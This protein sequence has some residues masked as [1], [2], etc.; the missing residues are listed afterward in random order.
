MSTL[1][2]REDVIVV[3]SISCIYGA[4][5]PND[6]KKLSIE[7][8]VGDTINRDDLMIT[9]ISMLYERSM[10]LESGKFRV[11][12]DTIDIYPAY[13]DQIIRLELFGDDI[14]RISILHPVTGEIITQIDQIKLFPAKQFVVPESKQE[15]AIQ[16]MLAELKERLPQLEPLEAERLKKRVNY[17]I[18]MIR[19]VG[20][21]SGIENYSRLFDGR[22]VGAPPYC[23]LDYFPKDFLLIIDESHQSLPQSRA[24]YKGDF[25]RKK[26]LVDFGFRL[27]CAYDNRPLKFVEFEKYFKHTLFVSATPGPYELENSTNIVELIIRPTGLLDPLVEVRPITGQIAD[28]EKEIKKTV[29]KGQRVLLTTL[30]K[31]QAEDLTDFLAKREVKVRYMHSD[32]DT[33]DRIEL[34]RQLRS[35]E[36]DVLVGINLLREGLDLPEVS[37]VCILDADKEGFLRNDTS[38]I[39]TIGRAARNTEGRVIMYADRETKSMKKAIEITRK[40]RQAQIAYNKIHNIVP[41]T[42]IKTILEKSREIKGTKHMSKSQLQ[43]KIIQIEADMKKAA[44][45]LDF[46]KAIDLRDHLE[47]MKRSQEYRNRE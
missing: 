4:G 20:Y 2:S 19:E 43:K 32:I 46:E 37:L 33:L 25:S 45:N 1:L 47:D 17:D 22:E 21:C 28:I 15:N 34:I 11:R 14:D 23:L 10:I 6:F 38:F 24:M 16:L 5:N 13:D 8:K 44:T 30:T 3:A 26:N 39:Q 9:L 41:K 27:P 18:E 40:R 12:G 31:R 36:F 7:L 29:K 42:I 35:G